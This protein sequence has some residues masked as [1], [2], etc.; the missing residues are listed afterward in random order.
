ML[1][2]HPDFEGQWVFTAVSGDR[3]N[4]VPGRGGLL[5]GWQCNGVE[6]LYFDADR[7]ADPAK[8]VRGGIPVLF[9]V[10]GNLPGDR[11]VLPEDSYPMPQHGFV[12]DLPWR[13]EALADDCG[14]RLV[15][16]DGEETRQHYPFAFELCFEYRLQ[17]NAL[18]IRAVVANMA[19]ADDAQA[20]P[21]A[22]GLHP[23]FQLGTLDEAQ[24]LHLPE[25][26]FDHLTG[27]SCSTSAQIAN[28]SGGVDFRVDLQAGTSSFPALLTGDGVVELQVESPFT[29]VVV[30][31]DPPR[32]ML[33][34][35]PWSAR[36]G[37]LGLQLQPG[38]RSEFLC[39]YVLKTA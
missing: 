17:C 14:V 38:E 32:P 6:R 37:E 25:I 9:P 15:L 7:F 10:C 34:L 12:R 31:S 19:T 11:L 18:E 3:L 2:P 29:H 1:Q 35:E 36:R 8:S 4:V 5:A 22:L 21:F 24:L 30:W 33:C 28:L 39:R 13:L 26:C 23:Y 27:A 16:K 20:M